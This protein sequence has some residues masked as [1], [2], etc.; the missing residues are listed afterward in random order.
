[1]KAIILA[2]GEGKRLRPITKTI[3]KP[4][5]RVKNTPLIER[6]VQSFPSSLS[7]LII[8]TGYLKEKLEEYCGKEFLGKKVQYVH[9]EKKQGTYHALKLCQKFIE[10]KER[11][12]VFF[13][14]DLIDKKTIEKSLEYEL[15][16]VCSEVEDPRKFGVIMLNND[17]SIKEIVEKPEIPPTNLVAANGYVLTEEIFNFPPPIH[18]TSNEYHLPVAVSSLAKVKK[19]YPIKANFWFP[20]ACPEDIERAEKLLK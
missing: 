14:D 7:E 16:V 13:A 6:L 18:P 10:K 4:L 12:S 20:I 3:P 9:Q 19:I 8:V 15:S 17:G 11:F 1:M 5:V 2:A